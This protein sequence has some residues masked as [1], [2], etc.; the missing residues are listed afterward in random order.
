MVK[1]SLFN[2]LSPAFTE[3]TVKSFF[4]LNFGFFGSALSTTKFSS[5]SAA[6]TDFTALSATPFT[7][8]N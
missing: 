6:F 8:S 1:P 7:A 3:S 2:V 5:P 4:K